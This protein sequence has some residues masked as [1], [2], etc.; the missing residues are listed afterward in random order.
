MAVQSGKKRAVHYE[1]L[2]ILSAAGVVTVHSAAQ[3]WY[4]LDVYCQEWWIANLYVAL[5]RFTVP[6]F[7]MISGALFLDP[8]YKLDIKRLYRRNI[9]HLVV[10]YVVWSCIY[11][12]WDCRTYDLKVAGIKPVLREM[13]AGRY[14]LW[15]L[16]MLI[17]IYLLL[18]ILKEWIEHA[19]KQ[20]LQYFLVLF[21]VL[22]ICS[23]TLRA[24]TVTDELHAILD[25]GKV[26]LV[27][28]YVGYFVL[29]YYISHIGISEKLKK[30]ICLC[31]VPALLCNIFVSSHLSRKAGMALG[32]IYD[33]YGLFTFFSAVSIYLFAVE[34][35]GKHSFGEKSVRWILGLSGN[36]LGVY[37]LHIWVIEVLESFGIHN[38]LIP[39]VIGIPLYAMLVFGLCV[40][41]ASLLRRIPGVGKYIC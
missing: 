37:V 21:F 23:E 30:G 27:C 32:Q 18:P 2:R 20:T 17:G 14:H 13:L 8:A 15:F 3:F 7:V 24:L 33:S 26:E 35:V 12:I 28:S 39:N 38:M 11:G 6:V 41:A 29:G 31:L 25:L 22:Q 9:L 19:R 5:F 10:L 36:T 1:L 4:T 40:L 16:P 34:F